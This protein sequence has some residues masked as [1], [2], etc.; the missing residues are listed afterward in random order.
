MLL[1][2][3]N[4][5]DGTTDEIVRRI[6]NEYVFRFNI[7]LWRDYEF[8]I[9]SDGFWFSDPSGRFIETKIIKAAYLRKPSFDDPLTV[10]EGGCLELWLRSHIQYLTQEIYNYCRD[11]GLVRLVEKGAEKRLGKLSQMRLASKHFL[12]PDWRF[13]KQT[14]TPTFS[15]PTIAKSLVADFVKNYQFFF[16]TKV[17]S[18]ML[19]PAYPWLLQDEV[20]AHADLTIVYVAGRSFAFVLDR[21]SFDGVD[22]RKYINKQELNWERYQLNADFDCAIQAFMTDA[23][24][25]FGRLDFLLANDTAY[26]LE[27]NPNGQWAWLDIDG[28]EGLFDAIIYE[29]TKNW[30]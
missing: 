18:G 13:L 5:I 21:S 11:N 17:E 15:K 4:S 14:V 10:P 24:L 6:G 28:N 12:V 1:I 27:V 29:L 20:E 25:Q 8:E 22:W 30:I 3:T 7:D 2:L 23:N 26:F 16:T 19:D 9:T